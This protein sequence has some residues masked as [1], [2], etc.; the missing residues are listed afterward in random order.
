[1]IADRHQADPIQG[2][3]ANNDHNNTLDVTA[4]EG[5]P[6]RQDDVE[7]CSKIN[8]QAAHLPLYRPAN[9]RAPQRRNYLDA[10]RLIRRYVDTYYTPENTIETLMEEEL[11]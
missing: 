9:S 2:D 8:K 6:P 11:S 7:K 3:A 5:N 4:P 1:M 10:Q